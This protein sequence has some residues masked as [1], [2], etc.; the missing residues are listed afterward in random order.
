MS[1]ITGKDS[2]EELI[3]RI[4]SGLKGLMAMEE[5]LGNPPSI[6]TERIRSDVSLLDQKQLDKLIANINDSKLVDRVLFDLR[7]ARRAHSG[8]ISSY[9]SISKPMSRFLEGFLGVFFIGFCFHPGLLL[10]YVWGF[11]DTSDQNEI[12]GVATGAVASVTVWL[13]FGTAWQI[14]M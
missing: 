10:L 11:L 5:N 8:H 6:L 2:E 3:K 1:Q 14:W 4:V 7:S 13:L 12:I 9:T